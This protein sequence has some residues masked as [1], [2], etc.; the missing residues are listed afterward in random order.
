MHKKEKQPVHYVIIWHI[1]LKIP[2]DIWCKIWFVVMKNIN[3][4]DININ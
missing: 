3:V 2:P 1:I 4:L